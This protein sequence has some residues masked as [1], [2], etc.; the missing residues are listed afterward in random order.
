MPATPAIY[1]R[2]RRRS[3]RMWW[4]P[5]TSPRLAVWAAPVLV[6]PLAVMLLSRP[7]SGP[8]PV[9]NAILALP[10]AG[11]LAAPSQVPGEQTPF[12][13]PNKR[14]PV[15][16]A[17]PLYSASARAATA[18]MAARQ[19]NGRPQATV[20]V[21]Q[22]I[23]AALHPVHLAA[24]DLMIAPEAF[25]FATPPDFS[26]SARIMA[27]WCNAKPSDPYYNTPIAALPIAPALQDKLSYYQITHDGAACARAG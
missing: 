2:R 1:S 15:S 4:R 17:L 5:F 16:V 21:T 9:E 13:S 7:I 10:V 22:R 24:E 25:L 27:D 8:S 3:R 19:S 14:M 18:L 26:L 6:L 12:G 23:Y 11:R 20:N